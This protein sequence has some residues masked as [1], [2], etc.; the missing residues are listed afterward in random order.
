MIDRPLA[1]QAA[2]NCM[3]TA[4]TNPLLVGGVF[5]IIVSLTSLL[6][7]YMLQKFGIPTY[8][9]GIS[10]L[11]V[12]M[13][14]GINVFVSIL[15][16]LITSVLGAGLTGYCLAIRHGKQ[17]PVTSLF[18]GFSSV[19]RIVWLQILMSAMIW[20][21]CLL[22]IVPGI[23]AAYRYRFA[24]LNL[25]ENPEISAMEAIRMSK[26]QTMGYKMDLF[27]LDLSFLGWL[28]L[29]VCTLG[30]LSIW[31]QPYYTLT[32]IAYYDN[33]RAEKGMLPRSNT[34]R[35][36]ENNAT[37]SMNYTSYQDTDTQDYNTSYREVDPSDSGS[38]QNFDR[39][40]NSDSS[41]S[42]ND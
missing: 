26:E 28:L 15:I 20:L 27:M 35:S 9:M 33:I 42:N 7:S 41:D 4:Q 21:W 32:T 36:Q 37:D 16:T 18:D 13:P 1:K 34:S 39:Y 14:S 8:Y 12:L 6:D 23:I 17:M 29:N 10:D 31:L 22:L 2:K 24:L 3:R 19:G 38:T 25:L 30:V 11:V 40:D 5:F